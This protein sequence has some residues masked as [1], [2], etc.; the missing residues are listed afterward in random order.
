VASWGRCL[1]VLE[2]TESRV[3]LELK[4]LR[5]GAWKLSEFTAFAPNLVMK[6]SRDLRALL[7]IANK[8]N[9][10]L[11]AMLI[12]LLQY[13]P[14]LLVS[15]D[16]AAPLELGMEEPLE[17]AEDLL[18]DMTTAESA[19]RKP[20]H[21]PAKARFAKGPATH[22]QFDG[23]SQDGHGTGGFVILDKD[24]REIIRVG[25]YYGPGRTNNEAE[26]FAMRDA[27]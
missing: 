21:L 13:R 17:L 23:G 2:Q 22:V 19:L 20:L 5:E 8:A 15:E 6:V 16:R 4:A 1:E 12:D 10:E 18:E 9:P 7:K 25:R 24:G 11:Q 27:V 14:K 26:G 3:L